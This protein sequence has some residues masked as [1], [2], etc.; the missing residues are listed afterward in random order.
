MK[1]HSAPGERERN[2]AAEWPRQDEYCAHFRHQAALQQQR[3]AAQL[4]QQQ[5]GACNKTQTHPDN[6]VPQIP[7]PCLCQSLHNPFR[8]LQFPRRQHAPP[9]S[10]QIPF[11]PR[12]CHD[13]DG[14]VQPFTDCCRL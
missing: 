2:P 3:E 12:R 5:D 1:K 14:R 9:S 4:K 6:P 8:C 7:V 13:C 11:L 10:D